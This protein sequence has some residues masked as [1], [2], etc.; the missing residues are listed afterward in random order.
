LSRADF[1]FDARRYP[2]MQPFGSYPIHIIV[3]RGHILLTGTVDSAMD[4]TVAGMRARE[5]FGAFSVE[6]ALEVAGGRSA[7]R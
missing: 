3:N 2:G 4:K 6:N 5:V 7:A 1:Y